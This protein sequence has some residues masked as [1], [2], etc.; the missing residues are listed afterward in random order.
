MPTGPRASHRP[1][2]N[3]SSLIQAAA[4]ARDRLWRTKSSRPKASLLRAN[5][6]SAGAALTPSARSGLKSRRDC[7]FVAHAALS[8][9]LLHPARVAGLRSAG[10]EIPRREESRPDLAPMESRRVRSNRPVE[11]SVYPTFRSARACRP[12]R[13][14]SSRNDAR[15]QI[16]R[17]TVSGQPSPNRGNYR[18]DDERR[19][20]DL[21]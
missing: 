3:T 17:A 14:R 18:V 1:P 6:T 15:W 21:S 5:R 10:R 13:S 8:P 9:R 20:D 7:R 11:A 16:W 2:A 12:R 4:A 19:R